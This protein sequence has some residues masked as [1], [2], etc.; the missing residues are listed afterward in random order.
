VRRLDDSVLI[1]KGLSSLK[2]SSE[3]MSDESSLSD[4]EKVIV[5]C[6]SRILGEDRV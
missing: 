1:S 4:C 2:A 6:F 5:L 3:I